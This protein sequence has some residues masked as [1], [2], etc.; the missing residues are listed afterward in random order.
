MRH[1]HPNSDHEPFVLTVLH[2]THSHTFQFQNLQFAIAFGPWYITL[3][4]APGMASSETQCTDTFQF[5]AALQR[6]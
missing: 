6:C 1:I 4:F 2:F 5:Y 3:Q